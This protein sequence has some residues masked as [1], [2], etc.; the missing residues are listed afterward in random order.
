VRG[1]AQSGANCSSARGVPVRTVNHQRAWRS[2]KDR[3][4]LG[5]RTEAISGLAT[6]AP[7][8]SRVI[9]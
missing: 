4:W 1:Q 9:S 6:T 7:L 2:K 8:S 5:E 3:T